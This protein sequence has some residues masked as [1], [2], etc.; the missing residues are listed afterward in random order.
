[1]T[2]WLFTTHPE[3]YFCPDADRSADTSAQVGETP[4]PIISGDSPYSSCLVE[5]IYLNEITT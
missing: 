1:M 2:N 4:A 3:M 5:P